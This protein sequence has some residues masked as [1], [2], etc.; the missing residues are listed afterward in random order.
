MK[1]I[2]KILIF[3]L[4][5]CSI[6]IPVF[7]ENQA[8]LQSQLVTIE[9]E[10]VAENSRIAELN[11]KK[12]GL[13]NNLLQFNTELSEIQKVLDELKVELEKV[14]L[15][16]EEAIAQEESKKEIF[17]KRLTVMYERGNQEYI[18]V[19]MQSKDIMEMTKRTEYLRQISENDKRIFTEFT[20]A[21]KL[22]DEKKAAVDKIVAEEEAK[23]S[24]FDQKIHTASA[25]IKEIDQQIKK[26]EGNIESLE[27]QREAVLKKLYKGTDVGRLFAEG[28]K[29][30]G[31]P[32]VWGGSSPST[33]FDCSGFVCWTYTQSGV[34]NLPRTTAQ[35]IY[36]QCTKISPMEA[37]AGD[38]IFFKGTYYSPHEPV[39]HVGIY[40]GNGQMLHCGDPI[41]YTSV[42]SAYWK[43]HFYGYGRLQ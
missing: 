42:N 31:Y 18:E 8:E 24:E 35:S 14:T 36:N 2:V 29:Y 13:K 20:E 43:S 23:K 39:T 37:R 40:A 4:L 25:E 34:Y 28:E 22:V 3:A 6:Q 21:R 30:L 16:L 17:Y 32:Y 19:F 26:C 9:S 15:E 5:V 38:L 10:M 7:A 11:G 12:E 1:G 33:S 27:S 41:Q